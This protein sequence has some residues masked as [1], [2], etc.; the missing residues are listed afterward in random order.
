M[1]IVST[2]PAW[3]THTVNLW[4]AANCDG[5][6]GDTGVPQLSR[7]LTLLSLS[8]VGISTLRC[9]LCF[10][11]P[12]SPLHLLVKPAWCAGAA[13]PAGST[14][15][16][17]QILSNCSAANFESTC[18]SAFSSH[19]VFEEGFFVV[20]VVCFFSWQEICYPEQCWANLTLQ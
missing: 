11:P 4:Q 6:A 5:F 7:L 1:L 19:L 8:L 3:S 9:G 2:W 14:H 10:L 17:W 15:S 16:S 20:C 18:P 13:G 12:P